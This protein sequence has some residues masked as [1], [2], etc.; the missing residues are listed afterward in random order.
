M[1]TV[2][3]P[4]LE[5]ATADGVVAVS[6][7][8]DVDYLYAAY[9]SGVFPWPFDNE[10][11]PWV[12]PPERAIIDFTD[13]KIPKS[14]PRFL[15]KQNYSFRVNSCFEEV[16]NVC[17]KIHRKGQDGTW[18]TPRII[19]A[20]TEFNRQG[21]AV[22]F[23]TFDSEDYLVGGLYGILIGKYFCGESMFYLQPGASKFAL[24]ETIKYLESLGA[25]WLD[26]QVMTPLLESFGAKLIS[27][28]QFINKMKG[29][30]T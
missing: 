29:A 22:S 10:L 11:I 27:R 12:S 24:L 15:K 9:T 25:T 7:D 18:I 8:I 14:L 26:A 28:E 5:T 23:E 2:I 1:G 4:P 19:D 21:Y 20:Y 13:Y 16:I 6:Y 3:F 30:I 17:A